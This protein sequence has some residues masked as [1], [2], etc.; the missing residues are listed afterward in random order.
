MRGVSGRESSLCATLLQKCCLPILLEKGQNVNV[1]A[2][3]CESNLFEMLPKRCCLPILLEK[4]Q[5]V[6]VDANPCES[7]L[8]EMLLDEYRVP[9]LR[10]MGLDVSSLPLLFEVGAANRTKPELLELR[11]CAGQIEL[12]PFET[13]LDEHGPCHV[14]GS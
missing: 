8:F 10:D 5:N 11:A 1:D 7:N 6:G 2:E 4:G 9:N 12:N 3:P 13:L 14:L